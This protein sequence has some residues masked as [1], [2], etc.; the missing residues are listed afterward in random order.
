M[1][2]RTLLS[3][4]SDI[5]LILDNYME[6]TIYSVNPADRPWGEW[7]NARLCVCD[8]DRGN[9]FEPHWYSGE[10]RYL[11]LIHFSGELKEGDNIK[12]LEIDE[13][14]ASLDPRVRERVFWLIYSGG[15][16]W[17]LQSAYPHNIHYFRYPI[18][19]LSITAEDRTRFQAFCKNLREAPT[20]D[21]AIWNALYPTENIHA[22]TLL[23]ILSA[24]KIVDIAIPI[25]SLLSEGKTIRRAHREFSA[26]LEVGASAPTLGSWE[27]AFRQ[28]NYSLVR[29]QIARALG[30]LPD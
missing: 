25:D 1:K 29:E 14:W 6:L 26:R 22:A 4:K 24:E 27:A 3:L 17:K 23:A 18:D 15:G 11:T 5:P 20:I 16:Y 12:R 13:K 7:L 8:I 21:P 30:T 19:R 28:R 9:Y 10:G 2:T